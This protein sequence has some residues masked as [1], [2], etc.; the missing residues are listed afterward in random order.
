[1]KVKLVKFYR[2]DC[3]EGPLGSIE[4]LRFKVMATVANESPLHCI[5]E[6]LCLLKDKHLNAYSVSFFLNPFG[7]FDLD[8]DAIYPHVHTLNGSLTS[9]D[10]TG[11]KVNAHKATTMDIY[12]KTRHILAMFYPT[13]KASS[14]LTIDMD[15]SQFIKNLESYSP[16]YYG[17]NDEQLFSLPTVLTHHKE[18]YEFIEINHENLEHDHYYQAIKES[19]L[20]FIMSP[21]NKNCPFD[22]TKLIQEQLVLQIGSFRLSFNF[23]PYA[24]SGFHLMIIPNDHSIDLMTMTYQHLFELESILRALKLFDSNVFMYMKKHACAGM[25]VAHMHIHALIP[26]SLKD[27]RAYIVNQLH[28]FASMILNNKDEQNEYRR[29]PLKPEQMELKRSQI[30][31]PLKKKIEENLIQQHERYSIFYTLH[32]RSDDKAES[33]KHNP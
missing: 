1:M 3:S 22:N 12:K 10:T 13:F 6:L 21:M 9:L 30:Q 32:S 18:T 7:R 19:K 31:E 28:Y 14:L 29:V 2:K 26:P 33:V 16:V 25:S 20:S 27:V 24:N 4:Q 8:I 5:P 11:K 17:W 15:Y 23:Q